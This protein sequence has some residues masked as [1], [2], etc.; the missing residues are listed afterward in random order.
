MRGRLNFEEIELHGGLQ[1]G[2]FAAYISFLSDASGI[3]TQ[4]FFLSDH[5]SI[6]LFVSFSLWKLAGGLMW[7]IVS[8]VLVVCTVKRLVRKSVLFADIVAP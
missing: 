1:E 2:L 6:D 4:S 3:I 7:L 8:T 5:K